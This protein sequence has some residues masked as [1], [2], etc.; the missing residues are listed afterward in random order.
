LTKRKSRRRS[1][2]DKSLARM[3]WFMWMNCM[4][5]SYFFDCNIWFMWLFDSSLVWSVVLVFVT[6]VCRQR[7]IFFPFAA[8]FTWKYRRRFADALSSCSRRCFQHRSLRDVSN[9]GIS[10]SW[11][12]QIY[13]HERVIQQALSLR[14]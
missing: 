9:R 13:R 4:W 11:A 10:I 14:E 6:W 5:R 7:R 2:H 12:H 8:L 3:S 1:R